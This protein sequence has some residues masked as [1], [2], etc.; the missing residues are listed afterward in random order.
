MKN[1]FQLNIV[2]CR[3]C[4][5]GLRGSEGLPAYTFLART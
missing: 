5:R 4:I 1:S 3:E 2:L